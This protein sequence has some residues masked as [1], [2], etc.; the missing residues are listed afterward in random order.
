MKTSEFEYNLPKQLIAQKAL[1]KRELYVDS[2]Y[3]GKSLEVIEMVLKLSS[4]K[5]GLRW[6]LEIQNLKRTKYDVYKK[7]RKEIAYVK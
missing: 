3:A 6:F 1:A 5:E 2:D 7:Q 4:P